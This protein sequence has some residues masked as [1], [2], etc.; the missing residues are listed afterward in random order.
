MSLFLL[1]LEEKSVILSILGIL[2]V[3]DFKISTMPS[4][5]IPATFQEFKV[6]RLLEIQVFK[7]K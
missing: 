1:F 5:E 3:L 7:D 6:S 2:Q 4:L